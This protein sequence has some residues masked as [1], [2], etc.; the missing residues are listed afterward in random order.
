MYDQDYLKISLKS[1]NRNY[2]FL[3]ETRAIKKSVK[4]IWFAWSL[5]FLN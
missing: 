2:V 3:L 1:A 5:F 4:Y